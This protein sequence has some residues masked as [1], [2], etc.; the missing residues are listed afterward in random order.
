MTSSSYTYPPRYAHCSKAECDERQELKQVSALESTV[1]TSGLPQH[2]RILDPRLAVTKYR[3]SAAGTI[4]Q[5]RSH[6]ALQSTLH[7]LMYVVMHQAPTPHHIHTHSHIHTP[8]IS[9]LSTMA[10]F[11]VDRFRACQADATRVSATDPVPPTWH[12]QFVRTLIFLKYLLQGSTHYDLYE[13]TMS[14]LIWTA[15]DDFWVAAENRNTSSSKHEYEHESDDEILTLAA[16]SHLSNCILKPEAHSTGWI[17]WQFQKH[18]RG[19]VSRVMEYYPQWQVALQCASLVVR[20]EYTNMLKLPLS[21]LQKCCLAPCLHHLHYQA[22]SQYNTGFMKQEAVKDMHL[23]LQDAAILEDC[24]VWG[25]PVEDRETGKVVRMKAAPMSNATM[26]PLRRHDEWVG[27][28]SRTVGVPS[29]TDQD[30]VS[31]PSSEWMQPLL[32]HGVEEK[33]N[34]AE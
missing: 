15:F 27:V 29:R 2:Q 11:C 25:L 10:E 9:L 8:T 13:T 31:I 16:I 22:L 33:L 18:A 5:G 21:T 20:Q 23:L 3:R 6:A 14:K 12:V 4:V 7:H 24:V 19:S 30:S 1:E 28:P 26:P 17:L 32:F 34:V